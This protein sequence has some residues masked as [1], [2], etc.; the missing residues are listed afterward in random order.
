MALRNA[1]TRFAAELKRRHVIRVGVAYIVVAFAL[2]QGADL[3]LPA[4]LLPDWTFRLLVLLV[5]FLFPIVLVLAWVYD[6]TPEG[7]KRTPGR[8]GLQ[9]HGR[10]GAQG[11]AGAGSPARG[12]GRQRA[13]SRVTE[14][15]SDA[16][17][18][19]AILPFEN[20]SGD[21]DTE[22]LADGLSEAII[23]KMATIP[24]LRVVPRTSSFRFKGHS[25]DPA[26][27]GA[28]L[29]V[30]ALVMGRVHQRGES[31]VVQ[32][33]LIDLDTESQL[34]GD[35]Y[36][37]PLAD[38]FSL[39]EAMAEEI[40]A[41]LRLRLTSDQK[42]QLRRRETH[43]TEAYREYMRGRHYWNKRTAEGLKLAVQHFQKA[44]DLD[45]DYGLAYAGLADTYDV[46]G[47]YNIQPPTDSYP[48]AKA[49][50]ARALE[51]DPALA[52]AHASLGYAL[53]FYDRD[54]ERAAEELRKAI[55]M[56]PTYATAHQ[57]YGWYLLVVGEFD[58]MV[59]SLRVAAELDPLSLIIN[60]HFGYAYFL[61]G[62]YAEAKAQIDRTL[63]L[64][65]NYPLA[66]QRLGNLEFHQGRHDAAVRALRKSVDL[67]HGTLTLGYLGQALALDGHEDEARRILGELER[68][69]GSAYVSPL[70][71]ALVFAGLG[72][73]DNV[74]RSLEAAFRER[75]SD[76]VRLKLLPWPKEVR[77][78]PRFL[79]FLAEVAP[80][81]TQGA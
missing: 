79:E 69:A 59:E 8:S 58:E 11:V 34:W 25:M 61:A 48:R 20:A 51:L 5:L 22:Y 4:L 64:D 42:S 65:A 56:K 66:Y 9:R 81:Q 55:Q 47:Y 44:I 19:L 62:R 14:S 46:L 23:N 18:S 75:T 53:L 74:M 72:E 1:F 63:E 52:E 32:A 13:S 67:S 45:P 6:L 21:D 38:I 37:E 70:D 16:I 77:E 30:R 24:D 2:L 28:E 26:E 39:Q 12:P 80:S 60:D 76:L 73:V 3:V 40:A 41:S 68:R 36:N 27:I 57:W 17:S 43:D 15:D 78:H 35:H 49:A 71:R 29:G 10:E 7:V 50:A 33:E 54:Y 31:L